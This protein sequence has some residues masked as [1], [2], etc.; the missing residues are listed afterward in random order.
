MAHP[1]TGDEVRLRHGAY[2]ASVVTLGASLRSLEHD[3]R[4]LVVPF[5]ADRMRPVFRGALL[6]PWPNRVVDGRYAFEGE[7]QQLAL[8]EPDRG[9]ALHGLLAWADWRV[10]A[11]AEN[12]V[13]LATELAPCA[14]YP[15]R[16]VVECVHALT[17]DGLTTTVAAR[18][19]G[20][21]APYGVSAHPYL[22]AGGADLDACVLTLP[23]SRYVETR[24]DR[25][26]PGAVSDVAAAPWPD[27]RRPGVVGGARVDHAFTGLDRD[28]DGRARVRLEAPDGFAVE[29]SWGR[30]LGWVQ[31]HTADRPEPE[32]DRAGLAVEPMTCPP[33]AFSTGEDLV[34]LEPGGRHSAS[35]RIAAAGPAGA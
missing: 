5:A 20:T 24:G 17:D 18:S 9:H 8:S 11:V 23:A 4:P 13:G 33:D 22:T 32:L 12:A 29:M 30:E 28:A 31:V 7:E 19:L 34:V 1:L 25:L 3:G 26:L 10:E 35:W 21:R 2:S 15:H 14:G 27:F 6:A 16:L